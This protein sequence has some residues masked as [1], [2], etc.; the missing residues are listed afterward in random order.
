MT[1]SHSSTH[2][3]THDQLDPEQ[4]DAAGGHPISG[5]DRHDNGNHSDV[6]V[7]SRRQADTHPLIN[8]NAGAVLALPTNLTNTPTAADA[9]AVASDN[10]DDLVVVLGSDQHH[11]TVWRDGVIVDMPGSVHAAPVTDPALVES[12]LTAA[13]AD[14]T[15]RGRD[16]LTASTAAARAHADTLAEMRTYAINLHENNVICSAGLDDFLAE[17][18]LPGHP[19][20]IRVTYTLTGHYDVDTVDRDAAIEDA[21]GLRPHLADI[22]AVLDGSEQHTVHID[23]AELITGTD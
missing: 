3:P 2:A 10:A 21:Q 17:F 6:G 14:L 11:V 1:T 5:S 22:D 9:A 23:D 13:V 12:V 16:P 19:A 20:K 8:A 18:D 4:N 7:P 15:R